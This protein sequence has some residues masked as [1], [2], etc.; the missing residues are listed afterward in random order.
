LT[1]RHFFFAAFLAGAFFTAAL[2]VFFAAFFGRLFRGRL[3]VRRRLSL[4]V[5][6]HILTMR[7]LIGLDVLLN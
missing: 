2:A 7:A 1:W 3:G 5:L 4:A 6:P